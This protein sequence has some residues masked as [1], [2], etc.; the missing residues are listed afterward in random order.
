MLGTLIY[1]TVYVSELGAKEVLERK[2]EIREVIAFDSLLADVRAWFRTDGFVILDTTDT[3]I[4]T[5]LCNCLFLSLSLLGRSRVLPVVEKEFDNI[6][7]TEDFSRVRS[8]KGRLVGLRNLFVFYVEVRDDIERDQAYSDLIVYNSL[9]MRTV[10]DLAERIYGSQ[11]KD[12]LLTFYECFSAFDRSDWTTGLLLGWISTE[13]LVYIDLGI[14]LKQEGV[15]ED[16]PRHVERKWHIHKALDF[17][18]SECEEKRFTQESNPM[19]FGIDDLRECHEIRRI[20]NRVV[21]EGYR[22]SELEASRCKALA[23]GA[24]WRFMRVDQVDYNKYYN[25]MQDLYREQGLTV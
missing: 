20:R 5:E 22:A 25:R 2:R 24:L 10:I 4:A 14:L 16:L 11:Y 23:E 9:Q 21:H 17:L 13:I 7:L 8:R 1:P 3:E 6:T 18:I 19:R 12:G 15:R